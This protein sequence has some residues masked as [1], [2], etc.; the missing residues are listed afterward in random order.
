[1]PIL[2]SRRPAQGVR[3]RR[4]WGAIRLVNDQAY[5]VVLFAQFED[6]VNARVKRLVQR[7]SAAPRWT[8]RRLWDT[9]NPERMPFMNRVAL[10]T[11]KG[12]ADYQRIRELYELRCRIA[13]G[14]IHTTLPTTIAT[15]ASDLRALSTRLRAR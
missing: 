4:R 7:R 3:D 5:F 13:H 11:D 14:T 10:L 2:L 15:Y 8:S 12:G 6:Q 1:M 9:V